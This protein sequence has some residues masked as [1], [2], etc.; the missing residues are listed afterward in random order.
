MKGS[1]I[2]LI[3]LVNFKIFTTN[4]TMNKI[5]RTPESKSILNLN[6]FGKEFETLDICLYPKK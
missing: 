2:S 6:V 1:E 3:Y 5:G 4:T